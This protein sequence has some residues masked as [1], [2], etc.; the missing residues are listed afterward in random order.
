M[1]KLDYALS[2][3]NKNIVHEIPNRFYNSEEVVDI[4]KAILCL[5]DHLLMEKITTNEINN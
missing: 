2:S 3:L 4:I 5:V 1:A